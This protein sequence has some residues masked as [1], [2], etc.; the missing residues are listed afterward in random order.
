MQPYTTRKG[1]LASQ[2]TGRTKSCFIIA[3]IF[4]YSYFLNF[5]DAKFFLLYFLTLFLVDVDCR[6]ISLRVAGPSLQTAL[7]YSY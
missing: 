3:N 6:I 1:G 2:P 7:Y 4:Y 5:C